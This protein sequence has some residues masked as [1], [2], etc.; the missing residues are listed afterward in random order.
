MTSTASLFRTAQTDSSSEAFNNFMQPTCHTSNLML[1]LTCFQKRREGGP[2]CVR[3]AIVS[4]SKVQADATSEN[5]VSDWVPSMI[6]CALQDISGVKDAANFL[7]SGNRVV[8]GFQAMN[9]N[10]LAV[11]LTNFNS[12]ASSNSLAPRPPVGAPALA[13]LPR[14]NREF[15]H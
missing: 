9:I 13:I 2:D 8:D 3:R 14:S 6:S 5:W 15:L 12:Q 10:I 7:V 4:L 1:F 11:N